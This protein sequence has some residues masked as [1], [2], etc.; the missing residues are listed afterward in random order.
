MELVP[1]QSLAQKLQDGPLPPDELMSIAKQTLAGLVAAHE[2][3][4]IHRDLKSAN[5]QITPDGRVK[6]LDFGLAQFVRRNDLDL[7][8]LSTASGAEGVSGTLA[9]MS[10]EQLQGETLDARSDI[11][12]LGVVLYEMATGQLPFRGRTVK[13]A[14]RSAPR[15]VFPANLN[16]IIPAGK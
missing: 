4:I 11:W 5:L 16:S 14:N 12:S 13:S 7:S 6:V 2:Q 1:G 15:W 8:T 10:P 3:G 9:Y